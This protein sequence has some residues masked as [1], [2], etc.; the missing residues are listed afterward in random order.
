MIIILLIVV[1]ALIILYFEYNCIKNWKLHLPSHQQQ[2]GST[3]HNCGWDIYNQL[4]KAEQ[5]HIK[6]L[7][8]G[9]K[10]N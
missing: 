2:I 10:I 7:S 6:V 1:L 9:I 3:L 5:L 4:M 8:L